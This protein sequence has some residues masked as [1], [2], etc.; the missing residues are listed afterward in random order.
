MANAAILIGNTDYRSLPK[1]KCCHDDVLAIKQLLGATEKYEEI[2]IIENAEADALNSQLRAAIDKV[3]SPEELFFYFTGHGHQHETEFFFCAT[4]FDSKRP[5]ET[6]ISTTEL[7]TLLKL[8]DAGLVVTVID[9]C[10]SGTLLVKSEGRWIPQNKDGFKNLVRIA[11]CLDSQNSLTGDPLSL[12]TEKFRAA[13]LRKTKGV[14]FYT[15]IINTL[16]DEFIDNNLQTPFFVS[17]HTGREQFV[18]DAKRL[19]GL[20]KTLEE[21]RAVATSQPQLAQQTAPPHMTLLERLRAADSKIVKPDTMSTFIGNFFD[22]LIKKVSMG[23]FTDFFELEVTE[24]ARFEEPTAER[25]II[26]VMSN[27][28][29][30]D[31]FVTANYSRKLRAH[32]PM[33]GNLFMLDRYLDDDRFEEN[34]ELSLNCLMT[35][36]QLRITFIPKFTNLQRIVLVVSCAPSLDHCYIFEIATQHML[37]DFGRFDTEG[38]EASRRWW[39]LNW[40]ASTNGIVDQISNKLIETVRGQL[41]SAENRLSKA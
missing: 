25:F 20:R 19:D 40:E 37:R 11:S 17:Q 33:F 18:D 3:Q 32:N 12:F 38:P 13:A 29:R 28:K 24:H 9:A 26:R 2:T 31:N 10:N 14:V 21:L 7:H 8:A 22:N 30:A 39:K 15:D 35:R 4:N 34:W 41:E 23:E 16:R 6:G 36:T 1:L 27:E 5:N